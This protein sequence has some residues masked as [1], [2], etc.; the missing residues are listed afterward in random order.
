MSRESVSSIIALV[1]EVSGGGTR[2]GVLG[3]QGVG[4]AQGK[5]GEEEE[6][7]HFK[8]YLG[9]PLDAI[10]SAVTTHHLRCA[11]GVFSLQLFLSLPCWLAWVGKT[12]LAR[13]GAQAEYISQVG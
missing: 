3:G 13:R 12:Y 5:E 9:T 1:L 7:R 4:G 2:E 10:T 6:L 8:K 11:R